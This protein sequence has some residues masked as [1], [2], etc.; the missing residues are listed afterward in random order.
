MASA[1][2]VNGDGLAD[3]I[4]GAYRSDPAAGESA[5]RSYVVFGK[6]DTTAIDLSAVAAGTGGFVINGQVEDD[7]SGR[8]VASAGDVNGDGLADLIV[9]AYRSDP[10]A[11]DSAGRSYVVFGKA[12]TTA[13][14]LSAVDA[15]MGGF[16]INGQ[17]AYERSGSSVASAGD[18]NGDGLADLIV[19]AYGSDPAGRTDA[20]R[21]Y[22]V[23][24]KADTSAI[25]LS[26]VAAGTGGFVINGQAAYDYNLADNASKMGVAASN[27]ALAVYVPMHVSGLSKAAVGVVLSTIDVTRNVVTLNIRAQQVAAFNVMSRSAIG[28]PVWQG[29]LGMLGMAH[30]TGVSLALPV[31][32]PFGVADL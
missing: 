5:G 1:G 6:A 3:L 14:D 12:D 20:G 2:D 23:F 13:I 7:N 28:Q 16:V 26:A 9:G 19:G 18:V 24:G 31:S 22:V 32:K 25:D 30:E 29:A 21:S 27:P 8:S 4:L 17:A 15:G 11:A 10:A